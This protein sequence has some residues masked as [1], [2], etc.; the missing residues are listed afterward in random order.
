M[1]DM[2]FRID[3]QQVVTI[4]KKIEEASN[5]YRTNKDNLIKAANDTSS[6]WKGDDNSEFK[7]QLDPLNKDLTNMADQLQVASEAMVAQVKMFTDHVDN[8][9]KIASQMPHS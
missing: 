7:R 5:I 9:K 2:N 1:G 3:P 6:Y 4:A 8:S